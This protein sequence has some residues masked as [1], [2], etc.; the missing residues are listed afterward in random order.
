MTI[1]SFAAP[2]ES[3]AAAD[4]L[5]RSSA[6]QFADHAKLRQRINELSAVQAR[7]GVTILPWAAAHVELE[8]QQLKLA[9]IDHRLFTRELS[10]CWPD[11][12][13]Q[14]NAVQKVRETILELFEEFER[15]PVWAAG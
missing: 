2:V 11:T 10:L 13:V 1:A 3:A 9:R 14:S 6:E 4:V 15:Q 12:A 7:L 5:D 8:Q